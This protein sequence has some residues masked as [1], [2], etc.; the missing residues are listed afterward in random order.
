MTKGNF[1]KMSGGIVIMFS[2]FLFLATSKQIAK[3][4]PEIKTFLLGENEIQT[5]I[6]QKQVI[7]DD[8]ICGSFEL[9]TSRND[10]I[11]YSTEFKNKN[12][13]PV[14]KVEILKAGQKG[15]KKIEWHTLNY[16]ENKL[17]FK[18]PELEKYYTGKYQLIFN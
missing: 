18:L 16:Q 11:I 4:S 1:V 3:N 12:K 17:Y 9:D 15:W 2:V 6:V 7:P 14:L 8:V 10:K 5:N 13:S